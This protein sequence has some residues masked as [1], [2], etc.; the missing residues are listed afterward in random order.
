MDHNGPFNCHG[1]HTYALS[2]LCI[3]VSNAVVE[4]VFSNVTSVF[5]MWKRCDFE[6]V[7]RQASLM[8]HS[9]LFFYAVFLVF[10]TAQWRLGNTGSARVFIYDLYRRTQAC[11]LCIFVPP[12]TVPLHWVANSRSFLWALPLFIHFRFYVWPFAFMLQ[13][14]WIKQYPS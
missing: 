10:L 5:K 1:L 7:L 14:T 11:L 6:C 3:P 2:C 9:C 12:P 8:G 13:M 4:W